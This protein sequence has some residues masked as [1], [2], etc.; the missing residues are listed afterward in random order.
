VKLTQGLERDVDTYRPMPRTNTTYI[1][2]KCAV[3]RPNESAEL[4][5]PSQGVGTLARDQKVNKKQCF[6]IPASPRLPLIVPIRRNTLLPKRY[7][8]RAYDSRTAVHSLTKALLSSDY[9][10]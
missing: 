3:T 5:V 6:H 1:G 4:N 10:D 8:K 7:L 2:C 9:P